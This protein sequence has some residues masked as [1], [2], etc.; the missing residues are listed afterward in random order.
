MDSNQAGKIMKKEDCFQKT[1]AKSG[2]KFDGKFARTVR[3][4]RSH[5]LNVDHILHFDC[6]SLQNFGKRS[7]YNGLVSKKKS[8]GELRLE[9]PS[10]TYYSRYLA[11]NYPL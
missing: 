2:A 3:F 9:I 8:H 1:E 11:L 7:Q 5:C 6:F 10:A 4:Q